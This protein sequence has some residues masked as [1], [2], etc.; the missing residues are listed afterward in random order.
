MSSSELLKA[1]KSLRKEVDKEFVSNFPFLA[2]ILKKRNK[3]KGKYYYYCN[4]K[5]N[6]QQF[7]KVKNGPKS[8]LCHTKSLTLVFN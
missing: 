7:L 1:K 6:I 8:A 3:Q 5:Y 2:V 4:K